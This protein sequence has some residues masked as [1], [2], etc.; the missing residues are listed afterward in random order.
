[1][2]P[3]IS[4][5]MPLLVPISTL[6]ALNTGFCFIW[7]YYLLDGIYAIAKTSSDWLWI[8]LVIGSFFLL[9]A[10]ILEII[11]SIKGRQKKTLDEA[12]ND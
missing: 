8:Y 7:L 1:M 4:V 9:A 2:P 11:F 5:I 12:S 6:W 3:V 10:I